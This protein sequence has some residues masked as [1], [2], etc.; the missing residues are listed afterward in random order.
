MYVKQRGKGRISGTAALLFSTALAAAIG[1]AV[2][3]PYNAAHAQTATTTEAAPEANSGALTQADFSDLVA[4]VSPAVVTI[5]VTAQVT[6]TAGRQQ[7]PQGF[8]FEEFQR[9]FGFA[10]PEMPEPQPREMR[11][12][13]TGFII[14][15]D[16][17]IVTN[18]HV[19]AD[20]SEVR[21]TLE[22]GRQFTAEVV[23]RDAPTD[24]AVLRIDAAD[25]P[26]VSFGSSEA[27]R[28]GQPVV[29][30]GNPFG[31]GTTV[32]TGIVS[33]L[34]RDIG[35]G[36][37]DA[38]IQTDAAI[39]RGNSGGPLFNAAGEVVGVNTAILSPTGGSVGIGFAAPSD[40]VAQV[41]ADLGA[42]G[43][44]SRGWLGVEIAPVTEDIAAALG[45]EPGQGAML[46]RV[47]ENSPAAEAG[48]RRGDIVTSVAGTEIGNPR[49][50]TRV[51]A[52]QAPDT[53][54]TL[55]LLRAGQPTEVTVTLGDR[56]AQDA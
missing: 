28:V 25:L 46:G 53:E 10:F 17:Q 34:G 24:L 16:G 48:L 11:G 49:D 8:P 42:G 22:D 5:E 51:I 20:A 37:F 9:R 14:G 30:I 21:V 56:A 45:L 40:M 7:M 15:T 2:L 54:V 1:G 32:T 52:G 36:P 47:L 6:P 31:L 38:F 39:N 12:L 18:A 29:A 23:G 27:L 43:S 44:V 13:G 50:L 3:P 19:V 41:V 35:S 55:G 4:R 33:A 26:T